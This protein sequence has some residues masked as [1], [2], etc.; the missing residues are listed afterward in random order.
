[1]SRAR[2]LLIGPDWA[3][4]RREARDSPP[5]WR[6]IIACFWH[7]ADNRQ[8]GSDPLF[9]VEPVV[10]IAAAPDTSPLEGTASMGRSL[11]DGAKEY[12]V[13]CG[14]DVLPDL[15]AEARGMIARNGTDGRRN[16][17]NDVC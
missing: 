15:S 12:L 11:R 10:I 14:R 2:Y 7:K 5:G 13:R 3:G 1:M 6:S 4:R 16:A 9:S 8:D 17:S